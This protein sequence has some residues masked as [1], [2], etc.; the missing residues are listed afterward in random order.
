MRELIPQELQQTIPKLYE[1]EEQTDPIAYIKLFVGGWS[2][3]ITE[4]SIDTDICFGYVISP[5]GS[6]LGYFSLNELATIKDSLGV[7]VERD[8]SFM[9]IPLSGIKKAQ[10]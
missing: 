1:A 8:L 5:F 9:P 7:G 10:R 2:W 6:E 3:Y 4:I